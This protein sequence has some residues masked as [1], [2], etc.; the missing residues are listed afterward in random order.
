MHKLLFDFEKKDNRNDVYVIR[1]EYP[2]AAFHIIDATEL[3]QR[4]DAQLKQ[5]LSCYSTTFVAGKYY[6]LDMMQIEDVDLVENK[7]LLARMFREAADYLY[8]HVM[9]NST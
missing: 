8:D 6:I 9:I 7:Y 2:V 3:T 4:E 5:E 1:Q